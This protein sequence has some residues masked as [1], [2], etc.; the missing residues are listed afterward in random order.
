M[1]FTDSEFLRI[2][3]AAVNSASHEIHGRKAVV[4]IEQ[5][6]LEIVLGE[7]Q[8]RKLGCISLPYLDVTFTFQ[9]IEQDKVDKF[10]KYFDLRYQRGGG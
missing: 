10:L 7:Q 5:G 6:T 9:N 8:Y 2:L 4:Q 1:G 3:P